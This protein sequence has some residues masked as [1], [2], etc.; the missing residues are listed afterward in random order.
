MATQDRPWLRSRAADRG[1]SGLVTLLLVD[2]GF[3]VPFVATGALN[4]HLHDFALVVI[5]G[6]GA[7]A[8]WTHLAAARVLG[9]LVG[10]LAAIRLAN[11]WVPDAT[12][13]FWDAAFMLAACGLLA[14]LV[15]RQALFGAGRMNWHR[16][17]GAVAAYLLVGV[18]FAQAY[19]IVAMHAP[20][21]F[22]VLGQPASY[23]EVVP[24]LH[25]YSLITLATVGYG[26]I[27]PAHPFARS[28]AMLEALF[29]VLFPVIMISWMVSLEAD[30]QREAQQEGKEP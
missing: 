27:S 7:Y 30:A 8:L 16:V 1:L 18:A 10:A 21:A 26:D 2:I 14:W 28:L 23:D 12:L 29:G 19:R 22:L 15:L 25:Y 13:R 24:N 9:A 20:G 17:Q 11:L 3:V 4:R 6:V 5:V